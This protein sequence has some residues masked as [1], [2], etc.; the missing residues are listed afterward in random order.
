MTD[1]VSNTPISVPL[2]IATARPDVDFNG[3]KFNYDIGLFFT[4]TTIVMPLTLP[5]PFQGGPG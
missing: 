3:F 2:Y 1:Y 4:P 5:P